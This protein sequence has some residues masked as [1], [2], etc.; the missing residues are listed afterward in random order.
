SKEGDHERGT[1]LLKTGYR[2]DPTVEHPSLGSIVCHELPSVGTGIPRH[3]SILPAQ[4]PARGGFL[5][6]EFDAFQVIDPAGALPDVSPI[7]AA[8][9][10]A[11]RMRDL[12][13][14]E[15]AFVRGRGK[16]VDATLHSE[17][18]QRARTMMTSE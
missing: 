7:V 4:W 2:P 1:Y 15:R 16:L 12:A 18:V 3:V 14:V 13:V 5:G 6:G 17:T 9:R 11:A 10:D 8:D